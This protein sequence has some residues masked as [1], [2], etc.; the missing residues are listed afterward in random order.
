[1]K[2]N[3]LTIVFTAPYSYKIDQEGSVEPHPGFTHDDIH[4]FIIGMSYEFN[5]L[6][7]TLCF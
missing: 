5:F 4:K 1:M 7:Y 2:S 6:K 3:E